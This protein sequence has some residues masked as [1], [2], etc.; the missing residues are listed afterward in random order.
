MVGEYRLPYISFHK[1]FSAAA[2]QW[3]PLHYHHDIGH[4]FGPRSMGLDIRRKV[5]LDSSVGSLGM[6]VPS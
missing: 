4:V 6:L 3:F 5:V 1:S 2:K